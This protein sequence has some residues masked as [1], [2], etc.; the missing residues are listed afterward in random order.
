MVAMARSM[1]VARE[2]LVADAIQACCAATRQPKAAAVRARGA[3][4]SGA[5]G[6]PARGCLGAAR[7]GVLYMLT[8]VMIIRG[9]QFVLG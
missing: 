8:V 1:Q 5:Y 6:V 4:S 9:L 7:V 2:S 3:G